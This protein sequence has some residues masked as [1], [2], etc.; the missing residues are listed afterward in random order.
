M[1][2]KVFQFQIHAMNG[3]ATGKVAAPIFP[4]QNNAYVRGSSVQITQRMFTTWERREVVPY[5]RVFLIMMEFAI[6][7]ISFANFAM[8]IS[9]QTEEDKSE[10]RIKKGNSPSFKLALETVMD[11]QPDYIYHPKT[12]FL[13][14]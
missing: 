1:A 11:R 5:Q 9:W 6:S 8:N 7:V 4:E 10:F 12:D 3:G 2:V 14:T 13:P